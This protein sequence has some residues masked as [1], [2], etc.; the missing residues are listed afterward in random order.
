[1]KY[2]AALRRATL[3][4]LALMLLS[5]MAQA[6]SQF[7]PMLGTYQ[8]NGCDGVKRLGNFSNWLGRKP[9]FVLD[10]FASDSWQSMLNDA[11]WSI[12]CW[13]RQPM[14]MVFSV[15][16]LMNDHGTLAEGASGKFDDQFRQLAEMLVKTFLACSHSSWLGIQW[17]LVSMGGQERSRKLGE[18][19]AAYCDHHA[20]CP[21]CG[22]YF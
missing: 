13:S 12:K 11:N 15:P 5:T 3:C 2:F 4:G 10:F 20:Q 8:G 17:R 19:L 16:M 22:I 18:V 9:D 14:E 1:M 21:R 6:D 7:V